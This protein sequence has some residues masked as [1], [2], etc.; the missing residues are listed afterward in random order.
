MRWWRTKS[1]PWRARCRGRRPRD[2][3]I[4]GCPCAIASRIWQCHQENTACS[5]LTDVNQYTSNCLAAVLATAALIRC[6]GNEKRVTTFAV[7]SPW[8]GLGRCAPRS[9][10]PVLHS[11]DWQEHRRAPAPPG[12]L[13]AKRQPTVLAQSI[14]RDIAWI[15][16]AHLATRWR[17]PPL[18]C[19]LSDSSAMTVAL[20]KRPATLWLWPENAVP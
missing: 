13:R 16:A 7:L 20:E 4:E 3:N 14:T 15:G 2:C 17:A 8:H 12:E 5:A 9:A 6:A 1:T 10:T 19:G 11:T 18:E